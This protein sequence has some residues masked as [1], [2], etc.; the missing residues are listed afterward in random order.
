MTRC[1]SASVAW[2]RRICA[3]RHILDENRIAARQLRRETRAKRP[4]PGVEVPRT[5]TVRAIAALAWREAHEDLAAHY[6]AVLAVAERL[7]GSRATVTGREIRSLLEAAPPA[8]RGHVEL[9]RDFWPSWF[10]KQ[11]WVPAPADGS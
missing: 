2:Y 3:G 6:G 5:A 9:A 11:W 7:L 4:P 1:P 10:T 8:H